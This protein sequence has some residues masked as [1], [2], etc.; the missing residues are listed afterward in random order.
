[1]Q[2]GVCPKPHDFHRLW[3]D[4]MKWPCGQWAYTMPLRR[5]CTCISGFEVLKYALIE[6]ARPAPAVPAWPRPTTVCGR[7][8][9]IGTPVRWVVC[10]SQKLPL[11][12]QEPQR[13]ARASRPLQRLRPPRSRL[14]PSGSK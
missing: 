12:A 2:V 6:P 3:L 4:A 8:Q 13:R 10:Q 9:E 7:R 14:V 11:R 1:M 5:R